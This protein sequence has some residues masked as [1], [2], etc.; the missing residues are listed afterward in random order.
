[1][2]S[3]RTSENAEA[4]TLSASSRQA[5]WSARFGET[6]EPEEKVGEAEKGGDLSE[7][8]NNVTPVKTGRRH[9]RLEQDPNTKKPRVQAPG[10]PPA[11][12]VHAMT[13]A[14]CLIST[15]GF[16]GVHSTS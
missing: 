14:G 2:S 12:G 4:A 13:F 6:S 7:E 8:G 11:L 16:A 1:M 3:G 9:N 15:W 10:V 5:S